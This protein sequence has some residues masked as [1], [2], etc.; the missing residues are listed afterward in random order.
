MGFGRCDNVLHL[1][2]AGTNGGK[3]MKA[4]EEWIN[5]Q[6][7]PTYLHE[8]EKAMVINNCKLTWRA[9]LE[10]VLDECHHHQSQDVIDWILTELGEN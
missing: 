1:T 8:V 9:A 10:R 7:I 6:D 4:F 2:G 3:T 5:K